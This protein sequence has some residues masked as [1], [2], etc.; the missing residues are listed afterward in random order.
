MSASSVSAALSSAAASW[1]VSVAVRS[2]VGAIGVER[3]APLEAAIDVL[4]PF[5][6]KYVPEQHHGVTKRVSGA[7]RDRRRRTSRQ[8]RRR[9]VSGRRGEWMRTCG[10][11]FGIANRDG[12]PPNQLGTY[13]V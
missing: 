13:C 11:P 10:K 5:D 3:H 12:R 9:R 6:R 1:R 8:R 4:G 7:R 2:D